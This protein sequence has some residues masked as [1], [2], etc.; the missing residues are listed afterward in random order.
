QTHTTRPS[1]FTEVDETTSF[2]LEFPSGALANLQTS[3]GFGMNYLRTTTGRGYIHLEPFQAY[4]NV[5][6]ESSQGPIA[7]AGVNQQATQM[8]E[9]AYNIAQGN[10]VR[11]PGEEG[12]RDMRVVD[13][14]RQSIREGGRRITLA[15]LEG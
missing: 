10:P 14:I 13:A 12:W 2:Q 4:R 11:V 9:D 7:P 3:F 6:G 1:L 8:D 15:P 5:R